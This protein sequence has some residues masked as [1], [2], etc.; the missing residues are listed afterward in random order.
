VPYAAFH[1]RRVKVN[2]KSKFVLAIVLIFLSACEDKDVN[3]VLEEFPEEAL[4]IAEDGPQQHRQVGTV[5]GDESYHLDIVLLEETVCLKRRINLQATF[6]SY[7]SE[8]WEPGLVNEWE[9]QRHSVT[10]YVVE[11][12]SECGGEIYHL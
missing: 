3:A 7:K 12:N 5:S 4:N 6:S 10:A 2:S 1:Y 11:D 8:H 9:S